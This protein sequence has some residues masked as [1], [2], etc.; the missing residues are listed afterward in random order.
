M[1]NIYIVTIVLKRTRKKQEHELKQI[2]YDR[3]LRIDLFVWLWCVIKIV[4]Y[5]VAWDTHT[6]IFPIQKILL[7]GERFHPFFFFKKWKPYK[8][9]F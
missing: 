5:M 6:Y 8:W 3:Y 1:T 2:N 9:I 4:R 7:S